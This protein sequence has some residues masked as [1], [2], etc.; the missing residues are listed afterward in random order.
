MLEGSNFAFV[1]IKRGFYNFSRV[2]QDIFQGQTVSTQVAR[3]S[4]SAP[5]RT[6]TMEFPSDSSYKMQLTPFTSI[7]CKGT[8]TQY[9]TTTDIPFSW[10]Q[11]SPIQFGSHFVF[12]LPAVDAPLRIHGT[13]HLITSDSTVLANIPDPIPYGTTPVEWNIEW[14]LQPESDDFDL[15]LSAEDY[16]NWLPLAH[17]EPDVGTSLTSSALEPGSTIRV[18]AQVMPKPGSTTKP[19]VKVKQ[20]TFFLTSSNVPGIAMNALD[21]SPTPDGKDL[22][23]EQDKN[24]ALGLEFVDI[25]TVKTPVG[26]YEEA[27]AVISS[28]D[29]GGYGDVIARAETEDGE[30]VMSVIED[31]ESTFSSPERKKDPLLLP[32]RAADSHIA[33]QWKTTENSL[34]KADLDDSETLGNGRGDVNRPGDG[35]SHYEEY[36][37]FI[38][39]NQHIRTKPLDVDY[40]L[41]NKM[42]S[43]AT[44]GINFFKELTNIKVH[45]VGDDD[46]ML[47]N[48]V[49]N[50]FYIKATHVTDQHVVLM[51]EVEGEKGTSNTLPGPGNPKSVSRI[52]I[53]KGTPADG[54][55]TAVAHE[56]AHSVN[57]PHHGE[58]GFFVAAWEELGNS[59]YREAPKYPTGL[60]EGLVNAY[61]ET[62][63]LAPVTDPDDNLP[64]FLISTKCRENGTQSV[65]SGAHN[66]IMRYKAEVKIHTEYPNRLHER[67][68]L[69]DEEYGTTLCA[70][71]QGTGFNAPPNPRH[72]GPAA[73]DR[74]DCIHKIV[75]SDRYDLDPWTRAATCDP[76]RSYGSL[77]PRVQ[78]QADTEQ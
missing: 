21:S 74:G 20:V 1:D 9:G 37:G 47:S 14:D 13:K 65:F 32:K 70:T 69:T 58:W 52:E 41:N 77:P 4:D 11:L 5:S 23:F 19:K 7:P 68:V 45:L 43:K 56:L 73:K 64:R 12:D 61:R 36:R 2:E 18:K 8:V 40:F 3:C 39:N 6:A 55:K 15:V 17:I 53:A 44:A 63:N 72:V 67:A 46:F 59:Q 28:F 34:S 71:T 57:V 22:Q 48:R 26:D 38:L 78:L 10:Y 50:P 62:P 54:M 25:A 60:A 51:Y 42:G 35:L 33:T 49:I 16:D 29:Y 76:I 24:A 31:P 66:C 27:K 30:V 75:V